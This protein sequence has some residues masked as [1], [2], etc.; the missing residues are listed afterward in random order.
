M[1][2]ARCVLAKLKHVHSLCCV[3]PC[4]NI[5]EIYE[6][7]LTQTL[8]IVQ[9][10]LCFLPTR[11]HMMMS[12]DSPALQVSFQL[13]IAGSVKNLLLFQLAKIERFN[14]WF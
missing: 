2:A 3:Q 4:E 1:L 5:S 9:S 11:C 13:R 8:R 7:I 10:L 14:R 6:S 12:Q